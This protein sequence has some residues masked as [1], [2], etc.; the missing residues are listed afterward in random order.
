MA[1]RFDSRRCASALTALMLAVSPALTAPE[2][3]PASA[4]ASSAPTQARVFADRIASRYGLAD[5]PK[6]RSI[7]FTFNVRHDGK[8]MSREW[9]WFPAED[10]VLFKGKDPK[11]LRVQA[12]Y[13]RKNAYSMGSETVAGIDKNFINDEYWLLFPLHL[14]W[15]KGLDLKLAEGGLLTVRYP[16]QGGYTPGDA[17]DLIADS[18]GTIRSWMFH[19]GGADTITMRADW[20]KPTDV[21]GLPIS[22]ERPGEKGFKVWFSGVKVTGIKG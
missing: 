11:G 1:S 13:S 16:K 14:A 10:S 17:Y 5:F 21:D 7:R 19:R 9:T 12:A 2:T 6:V 22:L 18:A 8:E 4:P 20:A 15:D 3:G